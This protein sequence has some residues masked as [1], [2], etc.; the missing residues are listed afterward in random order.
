M[1]TGRSRPH[2]G[3]LINRILITGAAGKIGNTLREGLRGRYALLRLSDIAPLDPAG[4]GE[5]IARADL[6]DLARWKPPCAA[7]I[8][9]E[10][11]TLA[12]EAPQPVTQD[13]ID[14]RVFDLYDEYCH[15][16][17]DRREFLRARAR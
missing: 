13:W 4:D 12:L 9:A 1:A 17:I 6:T 14:Q 7:S 15:G 3:V 5:E 8:V 10:P 2:H 11:S 16:R